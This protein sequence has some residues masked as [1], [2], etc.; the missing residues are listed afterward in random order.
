MQAN[1]NKGHSKI[2][3]VSKWFLNF[4]LPQNS[5]FMSKVGNHIS[6]FISNPEHRKH[7]LIYLS[8]PMDIHIA[9]IKLS[10][11]GK[12]HDYSNHVSHEFPPEYHDILNRFKYQ[13]INS[14]L[15]H[16][17]SLK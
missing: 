10:K 4:D 8:N 16:I 6:M 14:N 17:S 13:T 7:D 15:L 1:I 12:S 3:H 2:I 11:V 5:T 9:W